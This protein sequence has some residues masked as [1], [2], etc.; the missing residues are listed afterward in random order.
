MV[1]PRGVLAFLAATE[2]EPGVNLHSLLVRREGETVLEAYWAPYTAADRPL[3]YSVSKTFTATAMGLAL[4][5]G[6]LSL[7]DRLVDRLAASVPADRDPRTAEQTVHHVLSMSTGHDLDTVTAILE[8]G[9]HD[10]AA[11]YLGIPPS[12]PVG[13]RHTYH[14]GASWVVG[15][16]V[17]RAT[18]ETLL[19]YLR[20]RLLEP[21]GID[22]TWDTDAYGRELGFTGVHSTTRDL[23]T[24]AEAY[25][26]GVGL[27]DGWPALAAGPHVPTDVTETNPEWRLGYGYQVW[28]SREG[29][30]LDGAYGQFGLVL[31]DLVV[32][33]TSAQPAGSQRLLDLVWTHLV[34]A[35][36]DPRPDAGADA[37]LHAR[38]TRLELRRPKDAH[39]PGP[40][41]TTGPARTWPSLA[42]GSEQ[43]RLPDVRDVTLVRDGAGWA[44]R[45]TTAGHTCD[46]VA[47]SGAWHRT[48]L[49]LGAVEVPVAMAVGTLRTGH[50]RVHLCLTDTCHVLRLDLGPDG[51]RQAWETSPLSYE[52]LAEFVA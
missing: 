8:S 23:A 19:D 3:L 45:L 24:L 34:P 35:V 30:R 48:S 1:D 50:A 20:P 21:L 7:G 46:L 51:A 17:R 11:V 31:D 28:R 37:D 5:E 39:A 41:V 22:P 12:L 47:P 9:A 40:W 13:S 2:A 14:N 44:L 10:L 26:T 25:R 18:G 29:Y 32:A 33:I 15:E 49:R 6:R 16:L 52:S 27:P 4:A 42:I 36:R 38:L 43:L